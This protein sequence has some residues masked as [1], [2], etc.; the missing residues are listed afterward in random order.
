M[1]IGIYIDTLSDTKQLESINKLIDKISNDSRITDASLFYNGIGFNPFDIKCGMFNSTDLWNFRGKL[2]V[3]SLNC[4]ASAKNI[5]N[6]LQIYYYYGWE[7]DIKVLDILQLTHDNVPII[8]KSEKDRQFIHRV[9]G[10]TSIGTTD[11]FEQI[12]ETI[13]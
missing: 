2:I 12:L 11:N 5:V 9:T 4:L 7:N 1:N 8:C 10:T 13:L 6:N 3:T